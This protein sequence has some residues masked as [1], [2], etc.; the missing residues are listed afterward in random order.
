MKTVNLI[1]AYHFDIFCD[2]NDS[3]DIRCGGPT[4]L[5][6]DFYVDGTDTKNKQKFKKIIEDLLKKYNRFYQ[7][8][9]IDR[10]KEY[11]QDQI[12]TVEMIEKCIKNIN[13]ND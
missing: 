2:M 13:P 10:I 12:W 5:G 7:I 6:Y 3:F 1:P 11:R 8:I 4:T 9:H